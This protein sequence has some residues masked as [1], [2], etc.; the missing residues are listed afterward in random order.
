[1]KENKHASQN[2]K[3]AAKNKSEDQNGLIL[4]RDGKRARKQ[5]KHHTGEKEKIASLCRTRGVL[6]IIH[7]FS[8]VF[9]KKYL[10]ILVKSTECR[11][12]NCAELCVLRNDKIDTEHRRKDGKGFFC[13][14][15]RR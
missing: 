12:D 3:D 13:I 6:T 11:T 10:L 15:Y 14:G 8:S 9:V 7:G 5:R 1:M 4:R 2:E